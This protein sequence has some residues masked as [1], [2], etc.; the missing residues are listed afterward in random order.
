MG[1]SSL[2]LIKCLWKLPK[3][4]KTQLVKGMATLRKLI[5]FRLWEF[6]YWPW[7][8]ISH[9]YNQVKS[10]KYTII[11]LLNELEGVPEKLFHLLALL[12]ITQWCS[13]L[14]NRINWVETD[15]DF[16]RLN[17]P[18]QLQ[19]HTFGLSQRF[20]C[21]F[22]LSTACAINLCLSVYQQQEKCAVCPLLM[23]I[24]KVTN[25]EYGVVSRVAYSIYV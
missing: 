23:K 20:S 4:D 1:L 25:Q 5:F 18:I 19:S 8:I 10:R 17:K 14:L 12:F 24:T 22:C 7:Y 3:M 2:A 21:K 13:Y 16:Y 9:H 6:E 11:I 15:S